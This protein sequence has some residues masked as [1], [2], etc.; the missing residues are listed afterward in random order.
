MKKLY[1]YIL[2]IFSFLSTQSLKAQVN[3]QDSLALVDLYNN[4][5]GPHWWNRGGWL[6]KS[7][8]STWYGVTVTS[9]RVTTVTLYDNQLTGSIPS[10]MGNL[11]ALDTLE[12]GWNFNLTGDISIFNSLTNLLYFDLTDCSFTGSISFLAKLRNPESIWLTGN[13]LTGKIPVMN[14]ANLA[15]LDLAY[16]KLSGAIPIFKKDTANFYGQ[17]G[18]T[19]RLEHNNLTGNIN[20]FDSIV[21]LTELLLSNNQLTGKI[22]ASLNKLTDLNALGLSNNQLSGKIPSLDSLK[23]LSGFGLANNHFTFAGM[24]DLASHFPNA[25]YSPQANINIQQNGN[26]LSVSAGGTISNNTYN[27]YKNGVLF[28]SNVGTPRLVVRKNANYSVAVTNSIATQLT[29]YSDTV[30]VTGLLQN[31]IASAETTNN[32]S[33]YPN[34]VK[35]IATISFK[36]T[37]YSTIKLTDVEGNTLL[38]KTINANGK[39]T[40]QLDVSKY[41]SGVYYVS[42]ISDGKQSQT[43]KLIKE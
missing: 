5:N 39:T 4:T 38:T 32:F 18:V 15:I 24:E 23:L 1:P 36:A 11:V 3:T 10:S 28:K 35:T 19:I 30:A 17:Y 37:G 12:L 20:K 40:V 16:N 33:I 6:S 26:V 34:P 29:L 21:H 25:A 2:L 22:P 27:W 43:V 14:C 41:A 13:Q 42:L 8:V 31:S 9:D 7:P